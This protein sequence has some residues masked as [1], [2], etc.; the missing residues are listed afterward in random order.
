MS[1][2]Q[3]YLRTVS[4]FLQKSSRSPEFKYSSIEEFVLKHGK[5]MGTRSKESNNYPK[6]TPKECF[7]NAYLLAVEYD[8][9]YCEGYAA[10]VIPVHHAWCFDKGKVIDTTWEDGEEYIGVFF[11]T[12]YVSRILLERNSYGVIDNWEMKWPLLRGE[13]FETT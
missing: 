2:V 8:L 7:R 9:I 12:K 6:G 13:H 10:G 5:I 1:S 4:V 11:S 3:D